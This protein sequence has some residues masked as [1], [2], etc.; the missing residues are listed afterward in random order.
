MAG[1]VSVLEYEGTPFAELDRYGPGTDETY[2]TVVSWT[3]TEG[4]QGVLEEVA[5]M[6]SNYSKTHFQLTIAGTVQFTDKLVQAAC[7]FPWKSGNKLD[8][9]SVVLLECKS[10]DGSSIT[11]DGSITGKILTM[12]R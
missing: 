2:Q 9:E 7:S 4:Y 1:E 8:S 10:T 3:V 12:G 5:F 11:V 6:T